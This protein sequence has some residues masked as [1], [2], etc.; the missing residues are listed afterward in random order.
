MLRAAVLLFASV[1]VAIGAVLVMKGI[2]VPGIQAGGI[3]VLLILGTLFERWRYTRND[4]STGRR[5]ETTGERFTDPTTGKIVE[6]MYD[7]ST[8]ERRYVEPPRGTLHKPS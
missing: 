1:L 2:T 3:G 7:P 4:D 6:V 5:W 8:G